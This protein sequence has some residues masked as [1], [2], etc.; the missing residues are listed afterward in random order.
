MR[1]LTTTYRR[2]FP[3]THR[4]LSDAR[5]AINEWVASSGHTASLP[6]LIAA[7]IDVVVTELAANV[8]DHTSSE[9]FGVVIGVEAQRV[10]V[11][12]SNLGPCDRVP[13][14]E[15][16]ADLAVDERG[17]GLRIVGAICDPI[18]VA[19]DRT[20]TTITC[21]MGLDPSGP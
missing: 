3:A 19:G 15:S 11:E 6:A 21:E 16:W 8:V 17:R 2:Q 4:S 20:A 12:V 18:V 10:S 9:W 13:P 1:L 7:D 5:A 14:V